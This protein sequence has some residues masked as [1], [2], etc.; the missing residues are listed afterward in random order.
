M[1]QPSLLLPAACAEA[2][3]GL[4]SAAL[5]HSRVLCDRRAAHYA[6]CSAGGVLLHSEL[7]GRALGTHLVACRRGAFLSHTAAVADPSRGSQSG[8]PPIRAA[9]LRFHVRRGRV[10]GGA[11]PDLEIRAVRVQRSLPEV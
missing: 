10:R 11:N 4:L 3:S 7:C 1:H 5:L 9:A 2:L 8:G 6:P